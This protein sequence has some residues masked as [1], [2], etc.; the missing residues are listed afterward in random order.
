MKTEKFQLPKKYRLFISIGTLV[1]VLVAFNQC[2]LDKKTNTKPRFSTNSSNAVPAPTGGDAGDIASDLDL[3]D[4]LIMPPMNSPSSDPEMDQIDVGVKDFEQ[5][6]STMATLTGVS[7]MDGAIQTVYRTVVTQLPS[8][9]SIK[10]FLPSHQVAIT[11]LAAEYCERLVET[12]NLRV[13]IWPTIN[14]TQSPTQVFN[15]ANKAT[16]INQAI[17]R[18]LGPLESQERVI[19]YNELMSIFDTLLTGEDLANQVT[20]RKVIKGV[21]ISSLASAHVTLL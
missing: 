17:D 13:V 8:D 19:T 3:P 6:N 9:N 21:C 2:V 1:G 4:G 11:K 16:I 12:A 7:P 14:F 15:A 18:F 20:T 10:S 5:I